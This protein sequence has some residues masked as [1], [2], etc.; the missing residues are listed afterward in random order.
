MHPRIFP[1]LTACAVMLPHSASAE[2]LPNPISAAEIT[3]TA[4]RREEAIQTVPVAISAFGEAFLDRTRL[5]DVKDI[6]TFTPGF[7]GNSDDSYIDSIAIRGI[8]SNDYGIGGDPSIGIFKDGVY[9]GRTG[10]AVTSLFDVAQAEAL[11]GPQGFLFGRNAISGAISIMTNKPD[12]GRIS[13]HLYVGVANFGRKDA[14]GAINL[15]VAEDWTLRIAGYA[16]DYDGWIDNAF[17]AGRNDRLMGG[18]KQAGRVALRYRAGDADVLLSAEHERRRLDGAPYRASNDDR[19]VL[20]YLSEVLQRDIVIR[21]SRRDVDTDLLRPRDDGD[22]TSLTASIDL[23]LGSARLNSLTAFRKSDFHYLEDYD[24]TALQLGNYDQRQHARYV[25]Q[26]FRLM[27]RDDRRLTW[28]AGVSLYWEDVAARF[29]NQAA[30]DLVCTAGYGYADCGGMTMD[31]YGAPYRPAPGGLL[32]DINDVRSRNRGWSVFLDTNFHFSK[33]LEA[34]IGI[35]YARD[36]KHFSIDVLPSQSS[37][38][39]VWT[40]TYFTDGPVSSSKS[41][42]GLT[43][44]AYVRYA[45]GPDINLYASIT[46][47]YKAG[48]FGSFTVAAPVPVEAYRLV[49]DGTKP[50]AFAP[51]TIWSKELGIKGLALARTLS[52]DITGFHYRY[53]NLQTVYFDTESR[54]QQVVNVGSVT[55]YG[56]ESALNWKPSRYFDLSGH[57]TWTRTEKQDDRDCGQKD[58]SGLPNPIWSSAGVATGRYPIGPA[59][60]YLQGEW[61]HEGRRRE[62]FDWRGITR[63]EAYTQINLRLGYDSGRG[64]EIVAYAQNLFDAYFVRGVENGGDLTPANSWGIAQPRSFGVDLRLRFR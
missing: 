45:V 64:V 44:R 10:A 22:I 62:S 4:Q 36:R 32:T 42:G 30:E 5:D 17:T 28:S 59:E 60:I 21:G 54:T 2:D 11:R 40:F 52:F 18:N 57:V 37:L 20:D 61:M 49:P 7:S 6:V 47:G 51:E 27:S 31:L 43:P 58:C 12:P 9:Q 53:R 48:G 34:G 1:A 25:S 23:D 24:G 50:D 29:T 8:T 46:R 14:E 39:N 38:G 13:G 3:V 15:P 33:A 56:V 41:W 19:E 55:G 16:T 35:R 63:R 26:D